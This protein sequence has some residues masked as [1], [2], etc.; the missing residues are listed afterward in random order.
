MS[1]VVRNLGVVV[2]GPSGSLTLRDGSAVRLRPVV[3]RDEVAMR[4]FLEGVSPDSL[5]RR[6]FGVPDVGRTARSLVE[7][8]REA[9]FG[10]VAHADATSE[11]VAH[12]GWY[13]IDSERAEAAFLVTDGWQG[14][15]LGSLLFSRLA[16]VAQQRGVATLVADVLPGNGAMIAVFERCGYPVAVHSDAHGVEVRIAL[17]SPGLAPALAR[18]A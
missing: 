7:G 8:C 17:S 10:L 1:A 9:D 18:A 12:A 15:G 16:Q 4:T 6:F 3:P 5:R 13:R 14:R 11:I 2:G